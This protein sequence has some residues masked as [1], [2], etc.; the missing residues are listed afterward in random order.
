MSKQIILIIKKNNKNNY[1]ITQRNE[2][3][4]AIAFLERIPTVTSMTLTSTIYANKGITCFT[5]NLFFITDIHCG[6]MAQRL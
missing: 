1:M 3:K 4:P 6:G 2:D 5:E